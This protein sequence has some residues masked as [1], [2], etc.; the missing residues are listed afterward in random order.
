MQ[1]LSARE[2]NQDVG[3][4]KRLAAEAPV[5]ITDRGEPAFVLMSYAAFRAQSGSA[6]SILTLLDQK[7]GPPRGEPEEFMAETLPGSPIK[8][9]QFG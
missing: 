4:A 3:K 5:I 1:K 8:P 9:A 2:F 6:T 7:S